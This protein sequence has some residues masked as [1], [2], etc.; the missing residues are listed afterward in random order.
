MLTIGQRLGVFAVIVA[1]IF[2][3]GIFF[4]VKKA[5][6][7]PVG[8]LTAPE[9]LTSEESENEKLR[10][11]LNRYLDAYKNAREKKNYEELKKFLAR[12]AAGSFS[13]KWITDIDDYRIEEIYRP[14]FLSGEEEQY[15][16]LVKVFKN[17]SPI[18]PPTGETWPVFI[19]RE[20]GE[21]KVKIWFFTLPF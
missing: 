20:N 8:Q 6:F 5:F 2:G 7:P 15:A 4:V 11:F 10:E 12:E 13:E 17:G 18:N 14:A 19:V 9:I 1:I 21:F 16:A 3:G